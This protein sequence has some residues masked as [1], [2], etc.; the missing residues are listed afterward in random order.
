MPETQQKNFRFTQMTLDQIDELGRMMGLRARA[1][2]IRIA[3]HEMLRRK[4]AEEKLSTMPDD[5]TFPGAEPRK[6]GGPRVR[7]PVKKLS[8]KSLQTP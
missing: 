5:E 4:L 6:A 3:V 8:K 7:I 2:V 1:D